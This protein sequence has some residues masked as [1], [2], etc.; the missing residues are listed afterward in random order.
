MSEFEMSKEHIAAA[1]VTEISPL[2]FGNP[3]ASISYVKQKE[4]G[5]LPDDVENVAVEIIKS[6]DCLIDLTELDDGCIDGRTVIRVTYVDISGEVREVQAELSDRHERYKVA[7][8]GY[9]TALAMEFAFHP[10]RDGIDALLREVA[11]YLAEHGIFCG[12][13]SGDHQ[14][15]SGGSTDCGANDK[16]LPIFVTAESFKTEISDTAESLIR[17]AGVDF[18]RRAQDSVEK[19]W[20]TVARMSDAFEMSTGR[21]RYETVMGVLQ[22]MQSTLAA[23]EKKPLAVIKHLQGDHKEDFIVVNYVAGKTFSQAEFRSRLVA[24]FPD[25]PSD[26]I[27]QVFVVDVPR[28]VALARVSANKNLESLKQTL[29]ESELDTAD[30]LAFATALQ[31]GV[32]YQLATAATLTDGSLRTFI[33]Q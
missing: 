21:S 16:V 19:G 33:Y 17:V 9:M 31:A 2:G 3:E 5:E 13:H 23:D 26:V 4:S 32:S 30:E 24:Q 11:A 22:E 27:P 10:P 15:A 14:N 20:A 28:I 6:G 8:G 12:M 1:N 29:P 18:D 25:L 7:G